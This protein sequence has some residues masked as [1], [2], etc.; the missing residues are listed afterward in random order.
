MQ[1]TWKDLVQNNVRYAGFTERR[2]GAGE[3]GHIIGSSR[4][5]GK[6]LVPLKR[7]LLW[8]LDDIACVRFE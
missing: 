2:E 4:R 6:F 1:K 7:S 8:L 3:G 5:A